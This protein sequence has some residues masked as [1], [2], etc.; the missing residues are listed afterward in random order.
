M[1]THTHA[2]VYKQQITKTAAMRSN[3]LLLNETTVR[4]PQS[5]GTHA[6]VLHDLEHTSDVLEGADH[7]LSSLLLT[8]TLVRSMY[9]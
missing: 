4:T 3:I 7:G 5:P 1:H 8:G 6:V 9:V 2:Y